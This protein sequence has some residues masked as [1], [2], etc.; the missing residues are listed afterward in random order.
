MEDPAAASVH[1]FPR[2]I[3]SKLFFTDCGMH[4][5]LPFSVLK[6]TS[7]ICF[8]VI[9]AGESGEESTREAGI[10]RT[11]ILPLLWVHVRVT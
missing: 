6:I 9:L 5:L 11:L 1:F 10:E 7:K 2:N 3:D 4:K 8:Q